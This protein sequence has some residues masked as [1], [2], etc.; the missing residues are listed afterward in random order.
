MTPLM[1]E[2]VGCHH[3]AESTVPQVR[4][5][6]RKVAEL[7][8]T[9]LKLSSAMEGTMVRWERREVVTAVAGQAGGGREQG[10]VPGVPVL[11]RH[12]GHLHQD[13]PPGKQAGGGGGEAV[14]STGH[15]CHHVLPAGAGYAATGRAARAAHQVPL[16]HI[17]GMMPGIWWAVFAPH[18]VRFTHIWLDIWYLCPA[19]SPPYF[20]GWRKTN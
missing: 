2:Q 15:T 19:K 5:D 20:S 13:R 9:F 3:L 4:A 18:Q 10:A 17:S 7:R 16:S 14:W 11:L 8:S 6:P 12:P 1:Q